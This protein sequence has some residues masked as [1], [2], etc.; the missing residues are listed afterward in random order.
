MTTTS[1]AT[2]A[3]QLFAQVLSPTTRPDPYPTFGRLRELSPARLS[4]GTW[5]VGRW[6]QITALLRDP[7]MSSDRSGSQEDGTP[8]PP[9]PFIFRDP[10]DHDR[11]RQAAGADF[12]PARLAAMRSAA[13]SIADEI[14]DRMRSATE[15]DLV[16]QLAYPLPVRVICSLLGV[17]S[18]DEP[19]FHG[20]ASAL[21]RSLDPPDTLD[22]E[23]VA[24]AEQAARA[25]LPYFAELVAR[26]RGEPQN[27]LITGLATEADPPQRLDEA[28]LLATLMLLLIAG[29]ETT[30][31]LIANGALAMLRDEG[32]R[33]RLAGEPGLVVTFVEEMLRFDP[34]IQ[35]L[36][37]TARAPIELSGITIP[38]G[39]QIVLLTAAGNRDPDHFS[40]PDRIVP[41][42]PD[43]QH[44]GF[45]GG[46]HYCFGAAL[47]RTEA[48]VVFER[49]T[50]RLQGATL[51][52]DPPPYRDNVALRG[53][54][55][56]VVRLASRS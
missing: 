27:D 32:L 41:D 8:S 53:P 10:P 29:H 44:L 49:L 26:R 31:N 2:S 55:H 39:A 9:P 50:H 5:L 40:D 20:W 22:P 37:R 19:R 52:Q 51:A 42:R 48:Q 21:A 45:G 34:P 13:E 54:E 18:S 15:V 46:T 24:G 17:P 1:P 23:D 28:D 47:A 16:T 11:L 6:A 38:T 4:D 30:V 56:L 3:D 36:P 33:G 35:Y 25:I 43:N 12:T 7:R 14:L